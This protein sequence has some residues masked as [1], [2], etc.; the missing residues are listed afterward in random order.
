MLQWMALKATDMT[1]DL[2]VG[3]LITQAF[4]FF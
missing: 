3:Y 1:I 4:M 2:T